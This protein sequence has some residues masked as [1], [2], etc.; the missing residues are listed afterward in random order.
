MLN[1]E[2]VWRIAL[3]YERH[4]AKNDVDSVEAK[5]SGKFFKKTQVSL[6]QLARIVCFEIFIGQGRD[7]S[8]P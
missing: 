5:L 8:A 6:T 3:F 1:I 2:W 7:P 4:T